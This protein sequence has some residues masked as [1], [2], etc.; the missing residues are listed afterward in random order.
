MVS[1]TWDQTI[2]LTA[3]IDTWM[4]KLLFKLVPAKAA[5]WRRLHFTKTRKKVMQRVSE[6]PNGTK[7]FVH[8]VFHGKSD[9]PLLSPTEVVLD[10][11]L[12][13]VAGSETTSILLT[14]MTYCIGMHV[15]IYSKLV[16]E[17][18]KAFTSDA[19]ISLESTGNLPYLDACIKEA[20]RIFPPAS[21]A[22]MRVVP[23]A[24]IVVQGMYLPG[25]TI[26]GVSPWA[27]ARSPSNFDAPEE[28]R[29]ERWLHHDGNKSQ[30]SKDNLTASKPFGYGAKACL[31]VEL[32][33]AEVKLLM[34][35]MLWH[36][37]IRVYQDEN[38]DWSFRSDSKA[39]KSSQTLRVPELWVWYDKLAR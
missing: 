28:Y 19:N 32:A 21:V 20:L 9:K 14:A 39:M 31:G 22:N 5:A 27:A 11:S 24:G 33:F 15:R 10:V 16:D 8:Q 38:L 4:A 34:S 6:G 26:A 23:A 25:G 17:I 37:D 13:L 29:P 3:G 30:A 7:D 35:K 36:F 2:R 18:R 1:A 12:L